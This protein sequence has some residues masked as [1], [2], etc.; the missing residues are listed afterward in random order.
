MFVPHHT[1]EIGS[2]K[3]PSRFDHLL[4]PDPVA[5]QKMISS[6]KKGASSDQQIVRPD[7]S[8]RAER[9]LAAL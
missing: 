5:R 6:E 3:A 4:F 7:R 1:R 9:V 8:V 2:K